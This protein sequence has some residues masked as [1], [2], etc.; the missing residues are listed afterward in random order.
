MRG[1]FK[2]EMTKISGKGKKDPLTEPTNRRTG[3]HLYA[4]MMGT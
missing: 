2:R 3:A 4:Y 1:R